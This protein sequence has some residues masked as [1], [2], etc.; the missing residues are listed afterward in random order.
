M[1]YRNVIH[2]DLSPYNVLVWDERAIVIDFP[3]AIDARKNRHGP[4]LLE[5]DVRRICDHFTRYGVDA[6]P[7]RIAGDLWTAWEY[8]DLVPEELRTGIEI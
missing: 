4:A 8:A 6:D 3:Q 1:L 2:G 7:A 5:R